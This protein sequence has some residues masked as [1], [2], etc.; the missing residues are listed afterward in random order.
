MITE[1]FLSVIQEQ[2]KL[3][4]EESNL[5]LFLVDARQGLIGNDQEIARQLRKE[6][7]PMILVVNKTEGTNQR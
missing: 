2:T 7:K 3:A 4:I 1:T 6:N 5:I